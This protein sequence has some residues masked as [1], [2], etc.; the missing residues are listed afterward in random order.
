MPSTQWWPS[1][2]PHRALARV[3]E[4]FGAL[5]AAAVFRVGRPDDFGGSPEYELGT[6]CGSEFVGTYVLVL[7]VRLNVLGSRQRELGP[8]RVRSRV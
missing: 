5:L 6:T 2:W 3:D 7:T 4:T 1:V 8:S